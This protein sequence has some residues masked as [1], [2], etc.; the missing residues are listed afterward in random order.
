MSSTVLINQTSRTQRKYICQAVAAGVMFAVTLG[1]AEQARAQAFPV[2]PVKGAVIREFKAIPG[3]ARAYALVQLPVG[4]NQWDAVRIAETCRYRGK[5]GF[6]CE[7]PGRAEWLA[8][9][10]AF[11]P[12]LG[13]VVGVENVWVGARRA[14]DGYVRWIQTGVA[15]DIAAWG[16]WAPGEPGRGG[17]ALSLHAAHPGLFNACG[18]NDR[19]TRVLVE[20]R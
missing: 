2:C 5:V 13:G 15:I 17:T 12:S 10:R 9:R 3:Q 14:R 8:I 18:W 19:Y 1:F 7:M 4:F 6:I 16:A 11:G 20:F